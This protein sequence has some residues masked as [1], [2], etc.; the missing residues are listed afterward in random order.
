MRTIRGNESVDFN[1]YMLF[2]FYQNVKMKEWMEYMKR[3]FLIPPLAVLLIALLSGCGAETVMPEDAGTPSSAPVPQTILV[4]AGMEELRAVWINYNDLSMR[5]NAGGTAEEFRQR[6]EVM[7]DTACDLQLNTVFVH[8][9]AFSDAFYQSDIFPYSKYITGT[10]GRDPGYD[11][12]QIMV[13]E[14]HARSLEI[15]AWIN[16]YRVSYDPDFEKLSDSNPAKKWYNEGGS[17][18][19]RLIVCEQGIYYNPAS[20][21]AQKLIIDGV[22]EIVQRY[23]V[24]GIHYDDYFYPATDENVDQ[25]SYQAYVDA[26]GK[27]SQPDWRRENVSNFVSGLYSAVKGIAPEVQ[28]SISPSA[29]IEYNENKMFADVRLWAENTGYCDY[30]IPQVY[31]GF[32]NETLPF[33]EAVAQWG[34]LCSSGKVQLCFGLA[35]YKCGN[36]DEF[37]ASSDA[38]DSAR[39]EWQREKDI[40]ARQIACI[41]DLPQYGG[42]ALY[43]YSSIAVPANENAAAELEKYRTT[44]AKGGDRNDESSDYAVGQPADP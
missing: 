13:E 35:F 11:P 25:A 16:P 15:H 21:E 40:I 28:V 5:E 7:L 39:Y 1:K 26:G 20:S 27:Y 4:D 6:A 2:G 8:A 24:D 37:A 38:P 17:S 12:L 44:I 18:D 36:V 3:K 30:M 31:Y 32:E 42:Y 43:S 23:E 9:R 33:E 22:R 10:E 34:A 14:A 41:R 29:N 19:S